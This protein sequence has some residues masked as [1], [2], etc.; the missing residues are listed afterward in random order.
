MSMKRTWPISNSISFLISAGIQEVTLHYASSINLL[1]LQ[2]S[3]V[4]PEIIAQFCRKY[5]VKLRLSAKRQDWR[6]IVFAQNHA[7]LVSG[8]FSLLFRR[9]RL[10][11]LLEARIA[12]EP[13]PKVA[14]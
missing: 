13:V 8:K 5:V 9:E 1:L 4:K 3:R 11:D 10:D 2:V 14:S 6:V 12:A 7:V